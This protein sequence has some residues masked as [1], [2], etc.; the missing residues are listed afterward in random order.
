MTDRYRLA[1]R[2]QLLLFCQRREQGQHMP[3]VSASTVF[4]D[5]FGGLT[6]AA[7]ERSASC[8]IFRGRPSRLPSIRGALRNNPRDLLRLAETVDI[9]HSLR[10]SLR[11]FLRQIVT[12]ATG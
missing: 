9:D 11:S 4:N 5:C 3:G 6:D 1:L 10:K 7:G 2:L 12:D 8:L